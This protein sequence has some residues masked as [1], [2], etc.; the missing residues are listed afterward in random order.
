MSAADTLLGTGDVVVVTANRILDLTEHPFSRE[1]RQRARKEQ[2]HAMGSSDSDV[3]RVR[4][5]RGLERP[6]EARRPPSRLTEKRAF[7]RLGWAKHPGRAARAGLSHGGSCGPGSLP[8]AG[9]VEEGG[10]WRGLG[11]KGQV[12][13][14]V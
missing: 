6:R 2:Q 12:V 1:N 4:R 11:R 10:Q 9:Q 13:K 3:S 14:A 8:G 5:A 7:V